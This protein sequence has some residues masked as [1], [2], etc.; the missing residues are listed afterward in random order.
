MPRSASENT[1]QVA[2]K[3]PEEWIERATKIAERRSRSGLVVTR[4]QVLRLALQL[5]LAVVEK[6]R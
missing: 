2:F 3:I 1:F 5:G 6:K 4:A